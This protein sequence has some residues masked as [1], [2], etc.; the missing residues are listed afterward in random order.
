[1]HIPIRCTLEKIQYLW[2][3]GNDALSERG[4]GAKEG[5]VRRGEEAREYEKEAERMGG[6]GGGRET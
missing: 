1:M 3:A 6:G 2:E 5:R 4:K